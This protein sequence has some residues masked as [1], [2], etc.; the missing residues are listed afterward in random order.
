MTL[1]GRPQGRPPVPLSVEAGVD[2]VDVLLVELFL[3]KPQPLANTINMKWI[4]KEPPTAF[5]NDIFQYAQHFCAYLKVPLLLPYSPFCE[6]MRQFFTVLG[7]S[8][9]F[10]KR[11]SPPVNGLLLQLSLCIR[12]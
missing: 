12:R 3:G 8:S 6:V 2:E 5:L 9:L 1:G 11:K 10:S 7:H 4:L